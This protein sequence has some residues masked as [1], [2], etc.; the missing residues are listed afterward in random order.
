MLRPRPA[1]GVQ[2][3]IPLL[4]E[5]PEAVAH[6]PRNLQRPVAAGGLGFRSGRGEPD[7][8]AGEQRDSD[9]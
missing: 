5:Q 7:Q 4:A 3:E 8:R 9:H 2:Q 1:L 6:L